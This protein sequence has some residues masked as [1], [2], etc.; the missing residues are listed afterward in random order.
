RDARNQR[1]FSRVRKTNQSDVGQQLQLQAQVAFFARPSGLVLGRG[2]VSGG[3]EARIAPAA[4]AAARDH[5]P[6]AG[7]GEV[8][9]QLS[10]FGVVDDSADRSGHFPRGAVTAL[11]VTAFAMASALGLVLGVEAEMEKRVVVLAGG[12]NHVAAAAA[13]APAW[14]PPRD[15]LLTA[16]SQAAVAAVAGFYVNLDF[17]DEQRDELPGGAYAD[18]LAKPAAVAEL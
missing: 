2:L 16:E 3:G 18:E 8:V 9:Q 15:I 4:L 13:V 11:P 14:A 5:E 10:A 17:V 6:V 12:Q 1:R 7:F